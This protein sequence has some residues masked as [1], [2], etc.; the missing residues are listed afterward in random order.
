MKTGIKY[1]IVFCVTFTTW[2]V[3]NADVPLNLPVIF[4]TE[5]QSPEAVVAASFNSFCSGLT[6]LSNKT[7]DQA[8]LADVCDKVA[9]GNPADTVDVFSAVSTRAMSAET[10]TVSRGVAV[11]LRGGVEKRLSS[12][13]RM[14]TQKT[15]SAQ[16]MEYYFDGRWIPASWITAAAVEASNDAASGTEPGGLL[17]QRW[18]GFFDLGLMNAKQDEAITQAG[19]KSNVNGLTAGADYHLQNDAYLGGAIRYR[20]VSGDLNYSTGSVKGAD[21]TLTL[22][23]AY[24]ASQSLFVQAALIY[25]AGS[26][27][28]TRNISF[29]LAGVPT[30]ATAKSTTNTTRTG[31]S[32]DGYY[33]HDFHN[34]GVLSTSAS[35][36][37]GNTSIDPFEETG[38]GGFNL[39]V[40]AQSSDNTTLNLGAQYTH[41]LSTSFGAVIPEISATLTKELVTDAQHIAASFVADPS[42][43]SFSYQIP[44]RDDLYGNVGIGATFVF[45]NGRSGFVRYQQL[46]G[47]DKFAASSFSLGGRME[48]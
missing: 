17:S 37:F 15:S 42:Q 5:T 38:A 25:G 2:G 9:V 39:K 4:G 33:N 28:L 46:V 26:S 41:A 48:F 21:T 13:L 36:L 45:A 34:G 29:D 47:Y 20:S 27:D 43:T 35:L 10:T 30:T 1:P 14:A 8:Q 31:V 12:L 44:K 22:Y 18:G 3:A 23:G 7:A 6:S 11:D 24:F 16:P 32:I 19:F 40:A